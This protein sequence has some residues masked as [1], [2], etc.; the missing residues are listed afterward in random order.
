M[1]IAHNIYHHGFTLIELLVVVLIIGILAAV[2]VPQYQK[3]TEKTRYLEMITISKTLSKAI[4]YYYLET[5]EYPQYWQELPIEISGCVADQNPLGFLTCSKNIFWSADLNNNA[6][7]VWAK[8]KHL[9]M[10]Y[11]FKHVY[12]NLHREGTLW[13]QGYSVRGINYCK[14]ICGQAVCQVPV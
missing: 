3:A 11:Y 9:Q 1:K 14:S 2:A 7:G 12:N 5:G 6:F 13:C 8:D 10:W 4:E